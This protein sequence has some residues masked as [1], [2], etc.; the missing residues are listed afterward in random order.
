LSDSQA[1][2]D[3]DNAPVFEYYL[4]LLVVLNPGNCFMSRL[5]RYA[6]IFVLSFGCAG[7]RSAVNSQTKAP[8]K[9]AGANVAGRVT[10]HG[11]GAP[12]IVVSVRIQDYSPQPP[13]SYKAT[14]DQEGFYRITDVP[15]GNYQVAPLAPAYVSSE[16]A[17]LRE[18]GKALLLAEG[19]NVDGI[20]FSI[21]RGGVITGRITDADGRP[22]VEERLSLVPA[23]LVVQP[24]QRF[25]SIVPNSFQTDDR[26]V[27][28]IYGI[29]EGRYKLSV[30]QGDENNDSFGPPGRVP[31][32]RTYYPEADNPNDA[33]VI[34]VTEGGE[35]SDVD[36]RVGRSLPGFAVS[37]TVVDGETRRP[38]AG[39]RF[40]VRRALNGGFA[41]V[42]STVPS[43]SQGEF[44]I[45]N[46]T[47]GKYAVQILPM[48]GSE[49]RA[50]SV[51]F[52][53]VDQDVSGI[54]VKT[55]V[56]LSI[57]GVVVV[58]GK[59]DPSVLAK[60]TELRLRAFTRTVNAPAAF[61]QIAP[62]NADGSFRLGGL[63]PGM[64][65]LSLTSRDNQQL[66]NF[67]ILRVERDGVAQP[68]G[69]ELKAGEQVTGVKIVLKYGT[70][71]IRG[72]VKFE[73]GPL[74]PGARVSVWITQSDDSTRGGSAR[75]LDSRGRF[76]IEGVAAGTYELNVNAQIP[77]SHRPPTIVKQTVT[78][79]DGAVTD[80]AVT[81][82]LL[83]RPEP[84]TP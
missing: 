81:L 47:P 15:P 53:I 10:T 73:N 27:Y 44:R 13:P 77:Q 41:D 18:R 59:T 17:S 25:G 40:G 74:P 79:T 64:A 60:L 75:G 54:V 3:R 62:I 22:V 6:I 16:R 42:N 24:G 56:G 83:Q 76:L 31:Y 8:K 19:E 2:F 80:V 34:E 7:L 68:R 23:D 63:S 30:G 5:P 20:D 67:G 48:P 26:G 61:G 46:V 52:E 65:Y 14:T 66:V 37:G 51:P 78:V 36:I 9:V 45:E 4:V 21:E 57:S 12:G 70:G 35:V 50:E 55:A 43:N 69:L 29:P 32:K 38:V 72:E 33:R 28:R 84:P 11:K 39:L 1:T 82:D 49:V 71:S 58:D